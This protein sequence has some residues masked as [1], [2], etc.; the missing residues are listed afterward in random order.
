M[1]G[2]VAGVNAWTG[3]QNLEITEI[4]VDPGGSAYLGTDRGVFRTDDSGRSVTALTRGLSSSPV[5]ALVIDPFNS[6]RLW[7]AN[8]EGLFRTINAGRDWEKLTARNFRFLAVSALAASVPDTLY[9]IDDQAGLAKSTDAG[10][11]WERIFGGESIPVLSLALDSQQSRILAGT[12]GNGVWSSLDGGLTWTKFLDLAEDLTVNSILVHQ[13]SQA[14]VWIGTNKGVYKTSDSGQR[15]SF[16]DSGFTPWYSPSVSEL[17]ASPDDPS[18]VLSLGSGLHRSTDG[19]QSWQLFRKGLTGVAA[20][21]LASHPGRPGVF[22]LG[23]RDGLF[24]SQDRALSWVPA[25]QSID[26]FTVT[27]LTAAPDCLYAVDSNSLKKSTDGGYTWT[28]IDAGLPPG[29]VISDFQVDPTDPLTIYTVLGGDR[30]V[31]QTIDGGKS[32]RPLAAIPADALETDQWRI[33]VDP[34]DGKTLFVVRME[35]GSWDAAFPLPSLRPH[36][37]RSRNQGESWDVVSFVDRNA[38]LTITRVVFDPASPG[39]IFLGTRFGL[40]KSSDYGSSWT[41]GDQPRSGD[42]TALLI[43]SPNLLYCGYDNGAIYKSADGGI[44]WSVTWVD[45]DSPILS[46]VLSPHDSRRLYAESAWH[47]WFKSDDAGVTWGPLEHHHVPPVFDATDPNVEYGGGF[48]K[49]T[50]S[51]RTW[52]RLR[53][54]LRGAG[55]SGPIIDPKNSDTAYVLAGRPQLSAR[56]GVFKTVD[57]GLTWTAADS[58]LGNEPLGLIMGP[59]DNQRLW[60]WT[61]DGF[62]ETRNGAASWERL[63]DQVMLSVAVNGVHPDL[64]YAISAGSVLLKS[65][66]AGRS[67]HPI[68]DAEVHSFGFGYSAP[69]VLYAKAGDTSLK[70]STDAGQTWTDLNWATF[71]PGLIIAEIYV[72]PD[73]SNLVNVSGYVP[74]Y[75]HT[76]PE[77]K[78]FAS[79]DGG[80]TWTEL[81]LPLPARP[82]FDPHNPR[83]RYLSGAFS[84]DGGVTWTD[85]DPPAPSSSF[86]ISSTG[87][88]AYAGIFTLS[89]RPGDRL[90]RGQR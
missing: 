86:S 55:M 77:G 25:H 64:L 74:T 59:A 1:G 2:V 3:F 87:R 13:A 80:L 12:S 75:P 38:A 56:E 78:S 20:L 76:S 63:T 23:T 52:R 73:N 21:S 47:G 33:S 36:L 70:K 44:N 58:G 9:A 26:D 32:W 50:D 65:L 82:R 45:P 46:I 42:P 61:S 14:I 71:A 30:G 89:I 83:V 40:Y 18:L 51:G 67:W 79:T 19:G 57:G 24:V 49:S 22:Y 11:T 39:L 34:F 31:Y 16:S 69:D 72:D 29:A 66:D 15:W 48:W 10:Q 68:I 81:Q 4:A 35:P 37:F 62:Y 8:R 6:S 60:C 17:F 54:D 5:G 27:R 7:A 28:P 88:Q 43:D 90:P 84:L 53:H 41:F 85:L